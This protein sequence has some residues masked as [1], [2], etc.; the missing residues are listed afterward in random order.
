MYGSHGEAGLETMERDPNVGDNL[1]YQLNK[2]SNDFP[3]TLPQK[4]FLRISSK[5]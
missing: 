3:T 4:S 2:I 1:G 5:C